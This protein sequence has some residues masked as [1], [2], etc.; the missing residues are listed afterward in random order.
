[1]KRPTTFPLFHQNEAR[2]FE[3][4]RL[5]GDSDRTLAAMKN[6]GRAIGASLLRDY[7]EFAPWPE[8]P[9][10]LVLAGKGHNTGDALVACHRLAED[11]PGL[12]VTL[13]LTTGRE[14]W[15]ELTAACG[16][17]LEEALGDRLDSLSLEEWRNGA[18]AAGDFE[19]VMDGLYGLGFKPP[20]QDAI[21]ELFDGFRDPEEAPVR[22]AV[23]VPS[24]VGEETS[25]RAFPA[26]LT[27]IPGVAKE[28]LFRPDAFAFAGRCRF[29]EIDPFRDQPVDAGGQ[30]L[31]LCAP[32]AFRVL[33]RMR[34]ARSDKRTFG[35][36]LVLAGSLQM[37]GAAVMA[38]KAALQAGAGLVTTLTP[39]TLAPQIAGHA[40]EAM[41]RPLH[42][43]KDGG[44]DVDAV[45]ILA[46]LASNAH[47]LLIGPGL[48]LDRST[49]FTVCRI[50]REIQL[51]LVLDASAL[52][53]DVMTAVLARG[54][55]AGP[56]VV[57][58]HEGEFL[59][60]NAFKE[61]AARRD[62][63][64]MYSE[65]YRCTVVLKGHP[66][67]IAEGNRTAIAPYGGPVLARGG[68]GDLLS[69][70]LVTLLGQQPQS[71]FDAAVRAVTWHAAAGDAL[72]RE[73]GSC[74]VTTTEILPHLSTVLR[75][76]PTS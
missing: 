41:W 67:L 18:R 27:Y 42:L 16:K 74:A 21:A 68:T 23:D 28:A 10:I 12:R 71:A 20:L 70:M 45:R 55:T 75:E 6:A 44:L 63:V 58:P 49:L 11:L 13:L 61:D 38:T 5:Q 62:N 17:E 1:M 64:A 14:N 59:R 51:P 52:T 30:P 36:A 8:R 9:R 53:Q 34:P 66:T 60:M 35:H 40:P 29:L 2:S 76:E 54:T 69:G 72:A 24:G 3:E 73:R 37:P 25:P 39:G 31:E 22:V 43:S 33:N 4:S 32:Q 47:S 56:V 15:S 46:K 7:P 57:T 50:V 26:D 48:I 19:V 65:R